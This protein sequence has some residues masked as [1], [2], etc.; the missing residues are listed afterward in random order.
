M[1]VLDDLLVAPV[2]MQGAHA[3]VEA[4]QQQL[5]LRVVAREGDEQLRAVQ[6]CDRHELAGQLRML[7]KQG[8]GDAAIGGGVGHPLVRQH[9]E[10]IEV[11]AHFHTLHVG[12][13]VEG[14]PYS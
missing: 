11:A 14:V 12:Q 2:T 7:G 4:T 3:A 1:P 8:R 13:A 6:G 9:A 5:G 10:S